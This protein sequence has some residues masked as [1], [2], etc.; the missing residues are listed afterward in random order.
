[1]GGRGGSQKVGSAGGVGTGTG[2]L[3]FR[4]SA[5]IGTAMAEDVIV[6]LPVSRRSTA[7]AKP[8]RC[9][10]GGNG[11]GMLRLSCFR[12]LANVVEMTLLTPPFAALQ[13]CLLMLPW[14]SLIIRLYS[15]EKSDPDVLMLSFRLQLVLC[16]FTV[17]LPFDAPIDRVVDI[18][19]ELPALALNFPLPCGRCGIECNL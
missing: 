15:H 9:S 10:A 14:K 13:I 16:G 6:G 19:L 8:G 4:N 17:G 1:M 3:G 18:W 12:E 7:S 5:A 11:T 2:E